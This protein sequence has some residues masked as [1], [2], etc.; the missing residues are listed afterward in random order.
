MKNNKEG[1]CHRCGGYGH[2]SLRCTSPKVRER[3]E[4]EGREGRG[5]ERE[6]RGDRMHSILFLIILPKKG[7]NDLCHNCGGYGHMI[8]VCTSS[9][10]AK[11]DCHVCSGKGHQVRRREGGKG[12]GIVC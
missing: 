1:A 12:R 2:L 10:G 6:E 3:R 5:E 7:S 9:K 8:A 11:L 4:R